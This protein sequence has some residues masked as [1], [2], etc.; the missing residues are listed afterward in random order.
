[1]FNKMSLKI[2]TNGWIHH[3]N[4]IALDIVNS[5]N[6]AKIH[7]WNY[8]NDGVVILFSNF[9]KNVINNYDNVIIGPH[10]EFFE[11]IKI[12]KEYNGKKVYVNTLS[13]WNRKLYLKHAYNP[14]IEY[15]CIP[16]P[17]DIDK[18]KPSETERKKNKIVIY[19]KD[20]NS[21]Y[22]QLILNCI[23]QHEILKTFGIS[24][25]IYGHYNENDYLE[26]I[27]DCTFAIWIGRHESQ[28][29]GLQE[30]L[31]TGCPL[32]V[33]DILSMKDEYNMREKRYPYQYIDMELE[34]TA[35]PYFDE[36]CGI[37][38]KINEPENEI[39]EKLNIFYENVK[40]NKYNPREYVVEN[41]HVDTFINNINKLF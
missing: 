13:E 31:S 2:Y 25:I 41:L 18:F 20:V 12:C 16:F 35:V 26:H 27:R 22:L 1:M 29:I 15:V 40:N 4:K 10:I 3:K 30:A 17:I 6:K 23:S 14:S 5:S 39:C 38:C 21:K 7:N 24:L 34:A 8:E 9:D 33:F 32:F 37:I 36:R 19:Y 11:L 28:G